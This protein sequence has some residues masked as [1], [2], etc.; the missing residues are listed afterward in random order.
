MHSSRLSQTVS[1]SHQPRASISTSS[2][3]SSLPTAIVAAGSF[4]VQALYAYSGADTASLSFRQGDVIE[5]LSTL[6]SGWWDGVICEQQIRGWFP[7]NYVQKITEEEAAWARKQSENYWE[8]QEEEAREEQRRG[9]IT[10][11]N[12]GDDEDARFRSEGGRRDQRTPESSSSAARSRQDSSD[13]GRPSS[14]NA[15]RAGASSKSEDFW[16][17]GVD[18]QGQVFYYNSKTGESSRDLPISEGGED[19]GAEGDDSDYPIDEEDEHARTASIFNNGPNLDWKALLTADGGAVFYE[20]VRTGE[21]TWTPPTIAKDSNRSF[22]GTSFRTE[23]LNFPETAHSRYSIGDASVLSGWTA[24]AP[25]TI[26]GSSLARR[27][28]E[29]YSDDSE[30]DGNFGLSRDLKTDEDVTPVKQVVQ[31]GSKEA[32]DASLS[33]DVDSLTPPPN[34][35]LSEIHQLVTSSLRNLVNEVGIGG[36]VHNEGP[37]DFASERDRMAALSDSL[38]TAI[39]TLLLTSGTLEA[40]SVSGALHNPETNGDGAAHSSTLSPAAHLALRPFTRQVTTG[41]SKLLMPIRA[42]WGSLETLP[43]DQNHPLVGEENLLDEEAKARLFSE[44]A[45]LESGWSRSNEARIEM[46]ARLRS[47]LLSEA[48]DLQGYLASFFEECANVLGE[49]SALS[50]GG[51]SVERAQLR[52]PRPLQGSFINSAALNSPGGGFGGNWRGNGFVTLPISTTS[53]NAKINSRTPSSLPYTYPSIPL[54]A[55]VAISLRVD[56]KSLIDSSQALQRF[57]E[58]LSTSSSASSSEELLDKSV[59]LQQRIGSFL[60][61]VENI[62]IAVSVDVESTPDSGNGITDSQLLRYRKS[63]QGGKALISEL[64]RQ[65]QNLYDVAPTLLFAL[66]DI[67]TYPSSNVGHKSGLASGAQPLASSPL[68]H[69][70][71]PTRTSTGAEAVLSTLSDLVAATENISVTITSLGNIADIQTIAPIG[72]KRIAKAISTSKALPP[73][74]PAR[75]D[76]PVSRHIKNPSSSS[77]QSSRTDY[78]KSGHSSHDSADS[79]FFFSGTGASSRSTSNIAS[80]A[81]SAR[82]RNSSKAHQFFGSVVPVNESSRGSVST[83]ASSARSDSISQ[84]PRKPSDASMNGRELQFL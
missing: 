79:D 61:T 15:S 10:S 38:V 65:K 25:E 27:S 55:S 75:A 18:Q 68:A 72:P 22:V 37:R 84:Y 39:R 53:P 16:V 54:T 78:E 67:L 57:V 52:T 28:S 81:T 56:A 69:F 74:R 20:N 63:V 77:R 42:I 8:G 82:T 83:N 45:T 44:R 3:S 48:T 31:T 21:R 11:G 19:L 7:C 6:E 5:V 33:S 43:E 60:S 14:S 62:D 50:N 80:G 76:D 17:P 47:Q 1:S 24:R 32:S 4:Y 66:Q 51:L 26:G 41:L 58:S 23:E 9:S 73:I 49:A 2:S 12:I 36:I 64:E 40:S 46:E 59:V 34:P 35:L 71:P 29:A 70:N 13:E 30:L